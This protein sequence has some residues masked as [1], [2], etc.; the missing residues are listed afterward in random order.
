MIGRICDCVIDMSILER[1]FANTNHIDT[2][3]NTDS[4]TQKSTGLPTRIDTAYIHTVM[5][6][7]AG[8]ACPICITKFHI[9][10]INNKTL[11]ATMPCKHLFCHACIEK[12]VNNRS[13][14]QVPCPLCRDILEELY[15]NK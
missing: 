9:L 13:M 2:D 14:T 7:F 8:D 6:T 5:K 3:T 1:L 11:A 15:I 12:Y 4:E 10:E